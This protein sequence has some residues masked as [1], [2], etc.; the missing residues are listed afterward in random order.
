MRHA[1]QIGDIIEGFLKQFK[2]AEEEDDADGERLHREGRHEELGGECCFLT[3]FQSA[4]FLLRV[5]SKH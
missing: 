5:A 2:H 3:T 1:L 4:V